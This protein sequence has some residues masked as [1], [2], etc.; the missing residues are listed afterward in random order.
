MQ[1]VGVVHTDVDAVAAAEG[2][3]APMGT[4]Q[5]EA[6]AEGARKAAEVLEQAQKV[7]EFGTT[8]ARAA[9]VAEGTLTREVEALVTLMTAANGVVDMLAQ[10]RGQANAANVAASALRALA[11]AKRKVSEAIPAGRLDRETAEIIAKMT[12]DLAIAAEADAKSAVSAAQKVLVAIN[13]LEALVQEAKERTA[14]YWRQALEAERKAHEATQGSLQR[15]TVA[16][17]DTRRQFEDVNARLTAHMGYREA[18][19]DSV[20]AAGHT[21]PD[22]IEDLAIAFIAAKKNLARVEGELQHADAMLNTANKHADSNSA[23][24]RNRDAKIA[25]LAAENRELQARLAAVQKGNGNGQPAAAHAIVTTPPAGGQ[26][27]P[28]SFRSRGD[29]LDA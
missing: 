25:E 19:F 22:T 16:H 23:M 11:S 7:L 12:E 13:A 27:Q 9:K 18:A 26:A 15:E 8:T 28:G 5:R 20:V 2:A 3:P 17:S 6:A 10:V 14:A 21:R 1:H 29:E 4:E 24:V